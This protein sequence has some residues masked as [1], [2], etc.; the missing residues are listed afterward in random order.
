ME[1]VNRLPLFLKTGAAVPQRRD[2]VTGYEI[3]EDRK[4]RLAESGGA[5]LMKPCPPGSSNASKRAA[6]R[7]TL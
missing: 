2:A 4:R 5:A 3:H 1:R 6:S 7:A